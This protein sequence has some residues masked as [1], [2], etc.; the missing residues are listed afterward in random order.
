MAL[1]LEFSFGF[2]ASMRHT[3]TEQLFRT[4]GQW[5][6]AVVSNYQEKVIPS[7]VEALPA[8]KQTGVVRAYASTWDGL[9]LGTVD[10]AAAGLGRLEY[11]EGRP[12]ETAEE[13][14]MEA[15]TLSRLG[16]S[17]E[18]G[19]RISVKAEGYPDENGKSVPVEEDFV[20][21]GVLRDTFCR[22]GS[23]GEGKCPSLIVSR[24]W[25]LRFPGT[26]LSTVLA[27]AGKEFGKQ[28]EEA[29]IAAGIYE[30]RE[31]Y[32]KGDHRLRPVPV[33]QPDCNGFRGFLGILIVV[34]VLSVRKRAALWE[35]LRK[36]GA[37]R[38]KAAEHPVLGERLPLAVGGAAGPAAGLWRGR[39]ADLVFG[40]NWHM[41]YGI[42]P[43]DA[44]LPA[45]L[46]AAAVCLGTAFS[47][48]G[49][50]RGEKGGA[51]PKS[52]APPALCPLKRLNALVIAARFMKSRLGY[53]LAIFSCCSAARCL[54]RLWPTTFRKKLPSMAI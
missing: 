46:A 14:A 6:F 19:Q 8:A 12:P 53:T 30:N 1:L 10:E 43:A 3:V 5:R 15:Q 11:L 39:R 44:L 34:M 23:P 28:A 33:P 13:I 26:A 4:Y 27:D 47:L 29:G 48:L 16:Y 17:Y 41:E 50:P 7:Q 31:A 18:L 52:S 25:A 32:P 38:G 40:P 37:D 21:T 20:L 9:V 24:E 42:S 22:L 36:L 51:G 35:S 49:L 54:P 45:G 2:L